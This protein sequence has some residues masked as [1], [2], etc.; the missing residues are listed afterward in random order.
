VPATVGPCVLRD[1]RG[2]TTA[3]FSAQTTYQGAPLTLRGVRTTTGRRHRSA[4]LH[5]EITYRGE[6]LVELAHTAAQARAANGRRTFVSRGTISYSAAVRGPRR[7]ELVAQEGAVRGF[8]DRRAFSANLSTPASIRF[9]GTRPAPAVAAEPGLTAALGALA[10]EASRNV[11]TCQRVRGTIPAGPPRRA[12][13][14][15]SGHELTRRAMLPQSAPRLRAAS[16]IQ[17][18]CGDCYNSCDQDAIKC[19]AAASAA[20]LA[21]PAVLIALA[22]CEDD[23]ENCNEDCYKPG[24]PC[25]DKQCPQPSNISG[26]TI[27]CASDETCCQDTCCD[28]TQPVCI[29]AEN[30][31]GGLGYCC[32]S[33]TQ[34]CPGVFSGVVV[35]NCCPTG[36]TC[37]GQACCGAQQDCVDAYWSFCRPKGLAFC[38]GTCCD[39]RCT[40]DRFG[41][42]TCCPRD[43]ICGDTCCAPGSR[44]LR[45]ASGR[46]ICC[47]GSLCGGEECCGPGAVCAQIV[48]PR[49][50]LR[51]YRCG[52]GTPCGATFCGVANPVCCNG[53]CC[54]SNQTCVNGRCTGAACPPGQVPCPNTPNQCCPP[55][56]ICCGGGCCNPA[57]QVCCGPSRGCV[58]KGTPCV[59]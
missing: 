47:N 14:L 13:F 5:L 18:A 17:G 3:T 20:A 45:T 26:E 22:K 49:T 9:S 21:G 46:S 43:L 35:Q 34:G 24:H 54:A 48:D 56:F 27:C 44:C 4:T 31:A 15:R 33:G 16:P 6:R 28:P 25:C 58:P 41:D 8:M 10:T 38:Y 2:N 50:G 11:Q 39:G 57:T 55:N 59:Q 7:V 42:A 37:C 40:L 19:S 1:T 52:Y 53:V 23:W 51:H 30:V 29:N 12:E 32:P 36:T